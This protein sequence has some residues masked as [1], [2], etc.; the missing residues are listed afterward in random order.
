MSL[1]LQ[2]CKRLI[3]ACCPQLAIEKITPNSE[4]WVYFVAEVNEKYIFR[5]PRW[6]EAEAHLETEAAIL[7]SLGDRVSLQIPQF[8]F[9]CKG[10]HGYKWRFVGYPKIPGTPMTKRLLETTTPNQP[11]KDLGVFLTQLHNY[12]VDQARR[13]NVP[14][15]NTHQWQTFYKDFY[16]QIQTEIFPAL[17][18]VLQNKVTETFH[19]FLRND[20]H[21]QFQSRLIHRDLGEDHILWDKDEKR[22][23]GIIDWNDVGIGDPA[24]DF[25]GLLSCY[26]DAFTQQVTEHYQRPLDDT[27]FDRVRF[28]TKI[29]WCHNILYAQMIKNQKLF[30]ES[31]QH[32]R[33]AVS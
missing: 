29:G 10:H 15:F 4:G 27:V 20:Q 19:D 30:E 33:D 23:T 11:A 8:Q 12:P 24:F 3:E 17:D 18:G 9:I 5:F 14:Y 7:P 28:Y 1:D 6:S 31:I 16:H 25:T 22:I 13:V 26:G 2:L 21:F 32:L